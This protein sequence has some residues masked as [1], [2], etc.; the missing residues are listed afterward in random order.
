[1]LKKIMLMV[2][3]VFIFVSCETVSVEKDKSGNSLY[4][5]SENKKIKKKQIF[6]GIIFNYKNKSVIK[7]ATIEIKN[8]NRGL[9]Y[10]LTKSDSSGKFTINNFIPY[11]N[12]SVEIRAK[13][14]ITYKSTNGINSGFYKFPLVPE[15]ILKGQ[16]IDSRGLPLSNVEVKLKKGRYSYYSGNSK[17]IFVKTDSNGKFR[18]P[19][20]MTGAYVVSFSKSGYIKETIRLKRIR[21]G[22][23]FPLEI[24][25][26]K[27]A[28]ISGK[29][30]IKGLN[31]P[32][33]DIRVK[34]K[35]RFVHSSTSFENGEYL[36]EDLKPGSYDVSTYHQGFH[37]SKKESIVIKEGENL[38]NI[39]FL[40]KVKTPAVKIYSYRYTFVPGDKIQFNVRS[41]R[42]DSVQATIYRVP[43]NVFLA[44]KTNPIKLNP[45]KKKF[46][47]VTK[48]TEPIKNF[49]QYEW[50]YQSLQ[51]KDP[52][53]TGGYCIEIKGANGKVM[54][55]KFFTITSV[56][57][58]IK[59]SR[60]KI[61]AYV[62]NLITNKPISNAKVVVF[63]STPATIKGR[64]SYYRA[65]KSIQDLPVDILLRGKTNS[66]GV[67]LKK[68]FSSKYFSIL[69]LGQDGSYAI[70]NSG[71]PSVFDRELK[72]YFIYTDRP[73]YRAGD[74]VHFKIIAKLR[75]N[76]FQV[77]RGR[78]LYYKI[79]NYSTNTVLKSG[80][81]QADSWG[82]F[83]SKINLSK[84]V[85]LGMYK[86]K[87]GANRKKLY[88]KGK[89]YIEQYRKP[90]YKIDITPAKK[91]FI[92][93]DTAEFKIETKYFFGSPLSGALLKY[94]FY[95][96]K[97][98]RNYNNGYRGIRNYNRLKLSG[99]KYADKNGIAILK[100]FT[101]NYPYDRKITLEVTAIDKTN[102]S[103]TSRKIVMVGRGNFYIT[104]KPLKNFYKNNEEKLIEIQTK[105][106]S[107][108][109]V[110]RNIELK[111]YRYIWKPWQRVYVHEK[112]VR[113]RKKITTDDNGKAIVRLPK[114]F[115]FSGQFDLIAKGFD[116]RDNL[117][118]ASKILWVYNDNGANSKSKFKNL[119]ISLSKNKLQK[120]GE[121]TALIKS[122]YSKGFVCLTLEGR[123]VYKYKVV[124][125]KGNI[126]PVKLKVKASY[127]PNFYVNGM[128]QRKRALYTTSASVSI[129]IK[130]ISLKL[131][132]KTDKKIYK[133]G[134]KVKLNIKTT[135]KKGVPLKADLSIGVVDE[136]IYYVKKDFTPKI[137][138]YFYSK[139]SNWVLTSYSYPITLLAGAG[140][141]GKVKVRDKFEDTAFWQANIRTN[142]YG[143]ATISFKLPDNLTTWRIT[144]F[145][146]D[147][148]G[149]F[150]EKRYKFKVTQKIIA[151]IGKPR[152]V[153]A[154]D[155]INFIGIINS[156][157]KKGLTS[158]ADKFY[159]NDKQILSQNRVNISLPGF[160]SYRNYYPVT[161]PKNIEQLNLKYIVKSEQGFGDAIALSL[162]VYS[163]GIDY[164]LYGIGDVSNNRSLVLKGLSSNK[165]FTF[166]PEK[167]KITVNPMPIMQIF[168]AINYL[169]KY[170]YGCME[171]N[172]NRFVPKIAFYQLIKKSKYK[173]F[174]SKQDLKISKKTIDDWLKKIIKYQNYDGT[175]GW[176]N[177]GRGNEDV[178]AFVMKSLLVVKLN[179]FKIPKSTIRK[180]LNALQS[181]LNRNIAGADK[182]AYILNVMSMWGKWDHSVFSKLVLSKKYNAYMLAN[183][184]D[185]VGNIY[186]NGLL[187]N[188]EILFIKKNRGNLI[189]R[190]KNM[191]KK[192]SR[193]IYWVA[194]KKQRYAWAG[195]N[196]EVTADVLSAL[197]S[198]ND[199]STLSAQIVTSLSK[200]TR[201]DY[202]NSTK[203][204]SVVILALVKYF[205]KYK[206][207]SSSNGT[208]AIKLNGKNICNIY[209]DANSIKRPE[210]LTRIINVKK[211]QK[212]NSFN[213]EAT[214]LTSKGLTYDVVVLGKIFFKN[215][216]IFSKLKKYKESLRKFSNGITLFKRYSYIRRVEDLK[217]NEFLVPV[218]LNN[219]SKIKV[220][221]EILVKVRFS[222]AD[223]FNYLM[224]EDYLPSGFEVVK[225]EAYNRLQVYNRIERRD[226]RMIYFFSHV[227]KNKIYEVAYIIRAELSG[228]FIIKPA[229]IECM[230]E[231]TIQGWSG[232][233]EIEVKDK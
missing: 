229:K 208:V 165:D 89:F 56:G 128:M 170:P 156:N 222:A 191:Q 205:N 60:Y 153:I 125:L 36:I 31:R 71:S 193:G 98:N 48:W 15:S 83:H 96:T 167:I 151:R 57:V 40:L 79:V 199:S 28:T 5:N 25:L 99:E 1:M 69:V 207:D 161:I 134:E 59:R 51:I 140:K 158:I 216:P 174:F 220:G 3:V 233:G 163:R 97:I 35:G 154:G 19:K 147:R 26:Y 112:K 117:I 225:K 45:S 114:E 32:I 206:L 171:Q 38:K 17:P 47:V 62:T 145:A 21:E 204:S 122:R 101:G 30:K 148:V 74:L 195:S 142:K 160:G 91:F 150:G 67:Y 217:R 13:G 223:N 146:H 107:G 231:P 175:W 232:Q 43:M 109:A 221:D 155:E 76:R 130:D 16:I 65:R 93:G 135:N 37:S 212:I 73:V 41:F 88:S 23:I 94:R 90:E 27:P 201:G 103:I 131:S 143:R 210:T 11:I 159:L 44:G 213:F 119:E 104:I 180:G 18:I 176:W 185:A 116:W 197:L 178:T 100:L 211:N 113:F 54:D 46:K 34:A 49:T 92:N 172:I 187:K 55:R 2:A 64:R 157:F 200:R 75:K 33:G 218:A 66:Q 226:N 121:I 61:F 168:R 22:E 106:H 179:G 182:S 86:I 133:P 102:V 173:K 4:Q 68:Y 139:I 53:S 196:N 78:H 202:W 164:N 138:S 120:S 8:V 189:Y 84:N 9:G 177:G 124:K 12:Y 132:I 184:V 144:S 10:Y 190:L 87:V 70:A 29:I 126:T 85:P 188:Y 110:S 118:T 141:G 20:L 215:S 166:V 136:S 194:T 14:Y 214:D 50:R 63:D 7:N 123:D 181:F 227:K 111:L 80:T 186:R 183:L 72:K 24:K 230:Y 192:D 209:Y 52:L 149:R 198:I 137:V 115:K 105:S 58:V 82:T 169:A 162:P 203:E 6:S 95:E 42:L 228:K 81:L 127:A 77:Y 129:P 219:K 152:F 39:N 224:L 108:K